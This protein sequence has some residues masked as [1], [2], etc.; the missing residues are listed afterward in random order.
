[1]EWYTLSQSF[2]EAYRK[3]LCIYVHS[4]YQVMLILLLS[5]MHTC[6]YCCN[7]LHKFAFRCRRSQS[8]ARPPKRRSKFRISSITQDQS[9]C[10]SIISSLNANPLILIGSLVD[11]NPAAIIG[12]NLP[13]TAQS[14][15]LW[16]RNGF[17]YGGINS[18]ECGR[19]IFLL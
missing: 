3:C 16:P 9:Q 18:L 12:S 1:M 14:L 2:S 13:P 15:C 8:W 5:D 17:S 7:L 6:R 4:L 19:R 11:F 10:I